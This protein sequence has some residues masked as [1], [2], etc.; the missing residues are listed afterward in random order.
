MRELAFMDLIQVVEQITNANRLRVSRSSLI[1]KTRAM[2]RRLSSTLLE[3]LNARKKKIMKKFNRDAGLGSIIFYVV[4]LICPLR[5]WAQDTELANYERDTLIT[6]AKELMETTRYCALITL[7]KSGHPQVRTMDPFSPNEDMV[8]WMGTN[9]NSRKVR[10][11]RNDSRVTLYY[12][13]PNGGGYVVIKGNA[14][15]IND[16]EKN[17]RFWKEEW[18]EFYPDKKTTFTLIKV[19]PIELEIVYYK[20]GI[21]GSSKTWAVPHIEF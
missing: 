2:L 21:T 13:A 17:E 1:S 9:K 18:N 11:I 19:L 14:Y 20:R 4:I 12:E 16:P 8:V 15:L 10:E 5:L 3:P 7:D 6:A